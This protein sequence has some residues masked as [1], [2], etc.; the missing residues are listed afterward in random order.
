MPSASAS[1]TNNGNRPATTGVKVCI[2]REATYVE[3]RRRSERAEYEREK[4]KKK[5]KRAG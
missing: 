2:R 5:K 4:K 1:L 3:A